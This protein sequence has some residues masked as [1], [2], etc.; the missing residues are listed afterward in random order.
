MLAAVVVLLSL[1]NERPSETDPPNLSNWFKTKFNEKTFSKQI[2]ASN[3]LPIIRLV[4]NN[5]KKCLW[6]TVGNFFFFPTLYHR[7]VKKLF[8]FNCFFNWL[9]IPITFIRVEIHFF[10]NHFVKHYFPIPT[11]QGIRFSLF[12]I[13]L[14][15]LFAR[16]SFAGPCAG[17]CQCNFFFSS[18]PF[19][20][21]C[22]IHFVLCRL[23]FFS[24]EF[25]NK[26][27]IVALFSINW[28]VWW[29]LAIAFNQILMNFFFFLFPFFD[30][31]FF[32]FV[33]FCT[34]DV[35]FF[36]QTPQFSK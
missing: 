21:F 25:L 15:V 34:N 26:M 12:L 1:K 28:F 8:P 27:Q 4:N 18:I 20:I 23:F 11:M 6:N 32:F 33:N 7:F 3:I 19:F 24:L 13:C 31:F 17:V 29:S 22:H 2:N 35:W 14:V 10:F 9:Y 36:F 16:Y 5:K 30:F